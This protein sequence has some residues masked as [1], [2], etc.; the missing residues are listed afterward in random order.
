VYLSS[1]IEEFLGFADRVD[2]F[3][4]QSLFRS[5]TGCD[6]NEDDMLAAMFGQ[7]QKDHVS[8]DEAVA[9]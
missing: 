5:L 1:E 4:G 8:I 9:A 2:V 6:I 7:D 3:V